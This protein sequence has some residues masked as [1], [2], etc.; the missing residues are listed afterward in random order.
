[1]RP[2]TLIVGG[3][4]IGLMTARALAAEGRSVTVLERAGYRQSASWAGGGIL[5][6]LP[7]WDAPAAVRRLSDWS[8]ARYPTICAEL[9]DAGGVDPEWTRSGVLL[10]DVAADA[11]SRAEAVGARVEA[12]DPTGLRS[13]APDLD[14]GPGRH[15]FLPDMAQ[16]R[17][18]RLLRALSACLDAEPRVDRLTLEVAAVAS[19][20]V[21]GS[22]RL[23]DGR[24][25]EAEQ[26]VVAAGAW[27]A[28]LLAPLGCR[29]PLEPVRGQM[30]RFHLPR[31]ATG[32]VV[33]DG[34]RYLIP[35]RDGGLVVGSS[36]EHVGFDATTS[37]DV[38][39]DL[40]RFAE[41]RVPALAGARPTHRWAGLRP[42]S[43]DGIPW[44][45]P[46]PGHGRV[47]VATGHYRLGLTTAPATAALLVDMIS[48]REAILDPASYRVPPPAGPAV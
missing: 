19:G 23:S 46:V 33:L 36:L 42:G 15:L 5:G 35:R 39:A 38:Q 6:P 10:L 48:R 14:P 18:P 24:L 41:A 17:N 8:V 11:A 3:G 31:A 22:V 4:A 43:P 37:A 40:V 45:G 20:R 34:D 25:L 16:L 9:A 28:N 12:M 32:P 44:I 1:M 29:L 30:L 26:V 21:S 27:S 2:D 7:P 13:L 47:L